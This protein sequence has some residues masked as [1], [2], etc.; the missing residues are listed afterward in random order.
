MKK[1]LLSNSSKDAAEIDRIDLELR[2]RRGAPWRDRSNLLLRRRAE[3][4]RAPRTWP[5]L[6]GVAAAFT[7]IATGVAVAAAPVSSPTGLQVRELRLEVR[8]AM[9]LLEKRIAAL[10]L[11]RNILAGILG[12][13][14]ASLPLTYLRW[15]RRADHLAQERLEEIIASRP[16]ALMELL[17][18]HDAE[19]RLRQETVVN[20]VSSDLELEGVLRHHGFLK[21][22][23]LDSAALEALGTA[24]AVIVDLEAGVD[25]R[26]AAEII[27]DNNLEHVLAFCHDYAN[28]PRGRAT[29]ANSH[30]T[31]FSRLLEM[32]KFKEAA[33]R[34]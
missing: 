33:A 21:V 16:K 24:D 5:V 30:M 31:L 13:G 19:R 27:T 20:I 2:S 23:T 4:E 29:F 22:K 12:V 15:L 7:V 10:E 11:A 25:E 17:A 28:L 18:E 8:Q 9:F 26:R 34:G 14:I 6:L 32:L 3:G 1:V